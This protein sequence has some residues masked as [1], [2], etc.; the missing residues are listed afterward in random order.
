MKCRYRIF[1]I[2]ILSALFLPYASVRAADIVIQPDGNAGEDTWVDS[3]DGATVHGGEDHLFFGGNCSDGELRLYIRFDLSALTSASVVEQARLEFYMFGQNGYMD[4]DYD[5]FCVTESWDEATL[6]WDTQPT[7]ESTAAV[8][9]P[10]TSW[11]GN[12][13]SWHAITGLDALVKY[14]IDNPDQNH[15][16]V[17]QPTSSFY[18]TPYLYSSEH[19]TESMRPRLVISGELVGTGSSTWGCIKQLCR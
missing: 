7:C 15:G 10:G 9:F 5:I 18:G 13:G 17:I 19:S 2:V 4:Y 16:M 8:T 6:T 3:S 12:Y 14:W 11:Q 1:V